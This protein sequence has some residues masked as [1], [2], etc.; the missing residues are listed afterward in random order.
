[1]DSIGAKSFTKFDTL[2]LKISYRDFNDYNTANTQLSLT[3]TAETADLKT[4]VRGDSVIVYGAT[5]FNGVAAITVSIAETATTEKWTV[6]ERFPVTVNC[7]T[8]ATPTITKDID[9]FLVSSSLYNNTWYK[10]NVLMTDTTQKIKPTASGNYAV[11]VVQGGCSS[12][13]SS[14]TNYIPTALVNL[15]AGQFIKTFP[16]PVHSELKVQFQLN[17]INTV[18]AL[19]YD[20][21]GKLVLQQNSLSN[22]GTLPMGNLVRGSY[23]LRLYDKNGKLLQTEILIKD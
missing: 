10:D 19:L 2:R 6:S 18:K 23:L 1:M 14:A 8:I 17:G 5:G 13:V 4:I 15:S 16:N 3:A 7:N 22:A 21:S 20:V 11:K 9:N 12:I